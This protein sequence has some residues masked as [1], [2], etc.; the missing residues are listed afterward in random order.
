MEEREGYEVR[1]GK[2]RRMVM[3]EEIRKAELVRDRLWA[4]E[5]IAKSYPE[6]HEMRVRLENLHVER[7]LE[8][9]EEDLRD[10]WDRTL[11][12]RGS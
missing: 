5:E 11:H 10:L 1:A 8:A 9:V 3:A 12:P 7:V 6:G 2:E 4:L